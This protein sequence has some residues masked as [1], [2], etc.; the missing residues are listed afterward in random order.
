MKRKNFTI[1]KPFGKGRSLYGPGLL[2]KSSSRK[3]AHQRRVASMVRKRRSA[4]MIS[5]SEYRRLSRSAR[6][7]RPSSSIRGSRDKRSL[8]QMFHEVYGRNPVSKKKLAKAAIAKSLTMGQ[9]LR[10]LP[11]MRTMSKATLQSYAKAY[12]RVR[13]KA[14][15]HTVK[16][17]IRNAR[18]K[19]KNIC[20]V[21]FSHGIGGDQWCTL[22][23]G[24]KN[25][26]RMDRLKNP[27][28]LA[29]AVKKHFPPSK[30]KIVR[31]R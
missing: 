23:K 1:R 20:G 30:F 13:R 28:R 19:P 4:G 8:E 26:H 12:D 27:H 6:A 9:F 16:I 11:G 29:E 21:H 10:A 25:P 7:A 15:P 2:G 18:A 17:F 24:H 22:P 3:G 31:T 5:Q 14:N